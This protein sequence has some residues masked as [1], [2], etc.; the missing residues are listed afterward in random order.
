MKAYLHNLLTVLIILSCLLGHAFNL[1][2]SDASSIYTL[3]G[4]DIIVSVSDKGELVSLKN[5]QTGVDYAS[6]GYMWRLFYNSKDRNEIQIVGEG[7][8]ALVSKEKDTIIIKY[9][10]LVCEGGTFNCSLLLKIHIDGDLVRFSS[11]IANHQ[12]HTIVREFQYP[13]IHGMNLPKGYKLI[14]AQFGGMIQDDPMEYIRRGHTGYTGQ[15]QTLRQIILTYPCDVSMN[16]YL[17]AGND[18]GIYFGS[19]DPLFQNT[20]HGMRLYKDKNSNFTVLDC[21]IYKYPNCFS[22]DVWKCDANVI[23]PYKG[24]WHTATKI[25]RNW[26]DTWFDHRETPKW[27]QTMNSWQR[28]IFKRQY[29]EYIFKYP[30]LYGKIKDAGNSVGCNTVL[31]FA[32]WKQG[33][34]NS[35][36]DYTP[37]ASQGGDEGWS[38]A[39]QEYQKTGGKVLMYYNGKLIDRTSEYYL[40][41]D[42]SKVCYRD[43]TGAEYVEHYRFTADGTWLRQYEAH[44][45][46]VADNGNPVWRK[47]LLSLT[48]RSYNCGANGVFFDQLGYAESTQNWDRSREFPVPNLRIIYDKGQTLKILRDKVEEL[49]PSGEFAL[50]TEWLVDYTAQFCDFIHSCPGYSSRNAFPQL[51]K[52]TFPEIIFSDRE[53]RDDSDVE[54][55]VNLT[56]LRGMRNDIEVYRCQGLIT[57][58]PRYQAYLAKVNAIKQKYSDELL[59]GRYNDTDGFKVSEPRVKA[60]SFL[61]KERMAIVL[62]NDLADAETLSTKLEVPG[63]EYV[64][65]STTGNAHVSSEGTSIRLG[66]NDMAVLIFKL[67][68]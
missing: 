58:T 13:L 24:T 23:A 20:A 28:L 49:D 10:N 56:V 36:P 46:V 39:I 2:A 59:K 65:A 17:F 45:F 43:N 55:R 42:G 61:S 34:D 37:D 38:R 25:Y 53:I 57:E 50:G 9:D 7:Q 40:H 31:A 62:T 54:R 11:E 6:G 18:D 52:Y 51:F 4:K 1:A 35:Y 26:A 16:F 67:I 8:K 21:G 27:V 66:Q 60:A 32:W 19:H 14:D 48:E 33:H 30:D 15:D 29:G 12:T 44:A 3:Q 63:Y 5:L 64:E 47:K 41:G 68:N 22:G